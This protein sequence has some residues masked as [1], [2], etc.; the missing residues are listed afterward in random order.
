LE[1]IAT[2]HSFLQANSIST[3]E[4]LIKGRGEKCIYYTERQ[5][6][7]SVK[8]GGVLSRKIREIDS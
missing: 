6:V 5:L 8:A 4:K 3:P 2:R 7:D 1:C